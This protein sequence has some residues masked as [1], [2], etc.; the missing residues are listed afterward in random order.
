MPDLRRNPATAIVAALAAALLAGCAENS[1]RAPAAR[2]TDPGQ[3]LPLTAEEQLVQRRQLVT[4][5]DLRAAR[6]GS[7]QRAFY[8]YWSALDNEEW[9]IALEYFDDVIQRRLDTA[10]LVT[11]LQIEA[12][13]PP[14]KPLIRTVRTGR[15]GQTSVRYYVRR[16]NGTLRATSMTW[17]RDARRWHIVYCSTLDDSYALAV[18]QR[19]QAREDPP[20]SPPSDAAQRDAARARGAQA[21]AI[22]AILGR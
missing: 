18:Q 6:A 21:A 13:A 4:A 17:R 1:G 5:Q 7:V 14:V 16:A 12:Q 15:G 2:G 10:S 11:A 20:S 9:T 3:R 8:E 22:D 19:V